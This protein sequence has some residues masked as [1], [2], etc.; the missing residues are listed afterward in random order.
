[1]PVRGSLL[2][3]LPVGR[4]E[5][6]LAASVGSSHWRSASAGRSSVVAG[7]LMVAWEKD[8]GGW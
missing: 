3:L 7:W 1:M 6:G 8:D 2:L 5:A 4:I